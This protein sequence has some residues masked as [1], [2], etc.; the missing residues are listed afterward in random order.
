MSL[1]PQACYATAPPRV[2]FACFSVLLQ[3]LFAVHQWSDVRFFFN[4]FS[5]LISCI[6]T[7]AVCGTLVAAVRALF[8]I[9][10]LFF[11]FFIS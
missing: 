1:R 8:F 9:T 7:G 6:A 2:C 11:Y 3:G 10:F 4:L 5:I